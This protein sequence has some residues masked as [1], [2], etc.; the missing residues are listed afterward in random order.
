M[1][2]KGL[3]SSRNRDPAVE[4]STWIIGCFTSPE[5][6]RKA[7][8]TVELCL[9]IDRDSERLLNTTL[10]DGDTPAIILDQTLRLIW[11]SDVPLNRLNVESEELGTYLK[12]HLRELGITVD[13][14]KTPAFHRWRKQISTT[15]R[16]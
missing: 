13:V 5:P 14:T 8:C 9:W 2:M 1:A 11:N 6:I 3:E 16:S 15:I 7:N 12:P 4:G 10:S